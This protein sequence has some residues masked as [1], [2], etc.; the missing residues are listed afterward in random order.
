MQNIAVRFREIIAFLFV[1][2]FLFSCQ[3]E[4]ESFELNQEEHVF[5][6][7]KPEINDKTENLAE[8]IDSNTRKWNT[9]EGWVKGENVAVEIK[10]ESG[11]LLGTE[12]HTYEAKLQGGVLKGAFKLFV[13]AADG[14]N[15]NLDGEITCIAFEDDCKT[16][17]IIGI[18]NNSTIPFYEG[19]YARWTVV[20]N[21][22]G[23]DLSTDMQ[24]NV[25]MERAEEHCLIGAGVESFYGGEYI[26]PTGNIKVK[27][28][29]C[30][31]NAV[32]N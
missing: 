26:L 22:D 30:F 4:N 9:G 8:K 1:I 12:Y 27:S 28:M 20:D 24:F 10:N 14:F 3:M 23:T 16:V 13:E 6:L 25:S 32:G 11:V 7:Y 31:G 21:G 15:L 17:R 29:E 18:I 2:G 19:R 5:K